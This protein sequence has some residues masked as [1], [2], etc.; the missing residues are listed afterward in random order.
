M[1][2]ALPYVRY[3]QT[4]DYISQSQHSIM[5]ISVIPLNL[6]KVVYDYPTDEVSGEDEAEARKVDIIILED[7]ILK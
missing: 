7:G 6:T 3:C 5:L 2:C 1:S 4:H